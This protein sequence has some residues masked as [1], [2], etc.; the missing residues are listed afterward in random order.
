MAIL[1]IRP[2]LVAAA[3]TSLLS[4]SFPEARTEAAA[5]ALATEPAV[6]Q[7]NHIS[8][9]RIGSKGSPIILIPGLASPR[10]VWDGVAP[11]LAKSHVVYLVQV[12]GFGGDDPRANLKPGLLDGVVADIRTLIAKH[13]LEKP[14]LIGHSMGGLVGLMLAARHPESIDRLMVVDALPFF[15]VLMAPPGSDVTAASIEPQAARMRDLIAAGYGKPADPAAAEV[16][17]AG[18]ALKP[19]NRALVKQWAMAADPRAVGHAMYEDMTTDMRSELL[20]VRAPVTVVYAWNDKYLSKERADLFFR[21]QYSGASRASF[22]GI[23]DSAHFVML[24]Q[25]KEFQAALRAFLAR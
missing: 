2:L 5:F 16:Q 25:P 21:G 7:M 12:N 8:V 14:A 19:E 6:E 24:D 18:M 20:A 4:V 13:K 17:V 22:V 1:S 15:S 9:E 3:A 23:G 10:A 11:D